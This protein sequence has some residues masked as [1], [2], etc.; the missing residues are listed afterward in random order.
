MNYTYEYVPYLSWL[1]ESVR[2]PFII[3][4]LKVSYTQHLDFVGG[5]LAQ[6]I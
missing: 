4:Q 5:Y 6:A 2:N 3:T 1:L